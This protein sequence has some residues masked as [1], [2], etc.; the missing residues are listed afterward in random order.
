MS[1]GKIRAK[2]SWNANKIPSFIDKNVDRGIHYIIETQLGLSEFEDKFKVHAA[3]P[4]NN[5]KFL[6]D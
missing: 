4:S 6:T 1:Y 3:W 5:L 2:P